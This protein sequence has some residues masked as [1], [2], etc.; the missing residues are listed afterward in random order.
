M[1]LIPL[2]DFLQFWVASSLTSVEQLDDLGEDAEEVHVVVAV[3]L[4]FADEHEL[5]TAGA[6][7]GRQQDRVRLQV[8]QSLVSHK[9][10]L[11]AP[12]DRIHHRVPHLYTE[13]TKCKGY[14]T[15]G[16]ELSR[17]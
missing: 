9:L 7:D 11:L 4:D 10:L 6:R 3:V 17:K 2:A 5:R 15:G 12:L 13:S 1:S 16:G 8:L 14:V